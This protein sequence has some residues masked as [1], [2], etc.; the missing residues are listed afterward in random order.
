MCNNCICIRN[1]KEQSQILFK[2]N[3]NYYLMSPGQIDMDVNSYLQ[4]HSEVRTRGSHRYRYR[5]DKA[6]QRTLLYSYSFLSRTIRLWNKLPA[7]TVES[8]SLAV[9]NS[10]SDSPTQLRIT[11]RFLLS[12]FFTLYYDSLIFIYVSSE[13]IC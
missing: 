2:T 10:K 11:R 9:F 1:I 4:L 5:Q 8:N 6:T 7:E 12:Y 13:L 3:L